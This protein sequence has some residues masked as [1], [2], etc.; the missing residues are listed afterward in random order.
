MNSSSINPALDSGQALSSPAP[1]VIVDLSSVL[2]PIYMTSADNPDPNHTAQ[3]TVAR[4]HALALG[5]AETRV[6]VCCDGGKSFRNDLDPSYKANRHDK[7]EALVHQLRL[8]Q[9]QLRADGFAVWAI[10]GFE[11]DDLIASTVYALP[12]GTPV[13][14]VT[15]DKDLLQLVG[16]AVV[17]KSVRTGDVMDAEGVFAKL[18]VVPAQVADYLCLVGDSS[19]NVAGAKGIGPKRASELLARFG[20][21]DALYAQLADAVALPGV[22][23]STIASLSEFQARLPLTRRLIQLRTDAPVP[24]GELAAPRTPPP[25][26]EPPPM[27]ES[28]PEPAVIDVGPTPTHPDSAPLPPL[29]PVVN[30]KGRD[31][32]ALAPVPHGAPVEWERQLEPRSMGDVITLSKYVHDSR[33]FAAAYGSPQAVLSTVL[34]GREL[35]MQAMASLRAI[36]I[37]EGKPTLSADLIRAMVIRSGLATYFRC[38]ERTATRATF[39]TQRGDDPPIALSFTIEEAR[40]AWAKSQEKFDASAWGHNPADMLV[41]RAGAKLARLVYPDVVHGLYAPEELEVAS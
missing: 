7:D 6:A 21:L 34:A 40:L 12:V 1:V 26:E 22:P 35:G 27:P 28:E 32:Q 5:D 4:V 38:T 23:P 20:S 31:S 25:M 17:A 2:Y 15:G 37:V 13:T 9:D 33:L 41:A 10:P 18:G 16:D 39:E 29:A 3:A 36:H 30:A 8:A 19:D 24:V 14:I 11:A